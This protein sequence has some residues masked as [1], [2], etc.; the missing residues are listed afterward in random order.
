[1]GDSFSKQF[2]SFVFIFYPK[3]WTMPNMAIRHTHGDIKKTYALDANMRC[4]KK[5][6]EMHCP[7]SLLKEAIH[8]MLG[9]NEHVPI[10]FTELITFKTD[11]VLKQ[12][13]EN[14][15]IRSYNNVFTKGL[16]RYVFYHQCKDVN[17][18]DNT[19]RKGLYDH[20]LPYLDVPWGCQVCKE[21]IPNGVLMAVKLQKANIHV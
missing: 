1:M 10:Y 15:F 14:W 19:Y 12:L 4:T 11:K 16:T 9:S 8:E 3:K 7:Q 21:K 6:C 5:S 20:L 18:D 2:G 17:W 13:S